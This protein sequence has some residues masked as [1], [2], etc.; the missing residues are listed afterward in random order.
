MTNKTL[1][2][3]I[4][5][6]DSIA[7]NIFSSIVFG[8][9][10][11]LM[12]T[13]LVLFS[14]FLVDINKFTYVNLLILS[15]FLF[16]FF[17]MSSLIYAIPNTASKKTFYYLSRSFLFIASFV[18]FLIAS[19]LFI[20]KMDIS[21]PL[22][23]IIYI[24]CGGLSLFFVGMQFISKYIDKSLEFL[25][26]P[27]WLAF[28]AAFYVYVIDTG[29]EKVFFGSGIFFVIGGFIF[30]KFFRFKFSMP[31]SWIIMNTGLIF[32]FFAFLI[33]YAT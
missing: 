14:I 3:I 5:N 17:I 28:I 8:I 31:I 33:M 21:M 18:A 4:E 20:Y 29:F 23:I 10:S 16:L 15:S 9:G 6:K 19:S 26:I 22:L 1:Q 30:L 27:L 7:E 25:S 2:R 11:L 13:Q 32:F 12:V 24:L